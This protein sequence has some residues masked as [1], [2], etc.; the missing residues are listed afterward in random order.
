MA[1][2]I[3]S[4]IAFVLSI[5]TSLAQELFFAPEILFGNRSHT[6]LHLVRYHFN[7]RWSVNNLTQF[8]TEYTD[9][10]NN[11][12]FIRNTATY[13][14]SSAFFTN[15]SIGVKSPGH[16]ATASLQYRFSKEHF[17]ARYSAGTTYQIGFTFEQSLVVNY[18]PQISRDLKAYFNL[19]AIANLDFQEYQ[20]GLQQLRL[21]LVSRKMAYGIGLNLDQFNNTSKTLSNIGLFIKYTLIS[22]I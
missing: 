15:V 16:F 7:E 21:G 13:K 8:D 11:I 3:F 2:R 18:T 20:R 19:L 22:E 4:I 14:L 6:Y 9:D 17:S 10:S 1:T 12:F 5:T